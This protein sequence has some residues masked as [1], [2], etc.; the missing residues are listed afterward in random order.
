MKDSCEYEIY[1]C[2][3]CGG[4]I[5]LGEECECMKKQH[6]RR[7]PKEPKIRECP[8]VKPAV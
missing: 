7:Q 2:P 6:E 8:I 3:I 1:T 5:P 4:L